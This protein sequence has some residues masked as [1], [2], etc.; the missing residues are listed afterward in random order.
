MKYCDTT[1]SLSLRISEWLKVLKKRCWSHANRSVQVEETSGAARC[2]TRGLNKRFET[3]V[4]SLNLVV[5][6]G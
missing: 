5:C 6:A 2:V 3:M 4:V 1:G